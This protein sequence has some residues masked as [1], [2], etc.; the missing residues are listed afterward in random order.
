MKYRRYFQGKFYMR[1][2]L[3][4][5]V[6]LFIFYNGFCLDKIITGSEINIINQIF[7]IYCEDLKCD[8]NDIEFY[9]FEIKHNNE[10]YEIRIN[11]TRI[12]LGGDAYFIMDC[13]TKKIIKKIY[14][15]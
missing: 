8:K 11:D 14:G 5:I 9:T 7:S 15:E 13:N 3:L 4:C 10:L 6:F 2:I 12:D 1:K